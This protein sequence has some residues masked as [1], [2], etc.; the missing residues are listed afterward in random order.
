MSLPA[1]DNHD[2]RIR[3]Y[4][5][6]L[7]RDLVGIEELPLPPGYRYAFY[8]DGDRDDWIEI[9]RSAKEFA[10]YGQG[11][12][13][14]G[15]Y[16][17]DHTNELPERM[18]FVL[19]A[20]DDLVGFGVSAPSIADALKRSRGRL[21]PLGWIRMLRALKTN[22]TLDLFLIALKREYQDK[23]VNA[24]IMNHIL[25]G[26]HKMGIRKAE[27]G[28]QLETNHRVQSQWNFFKTEQHK[29]RRCFIKAL[30]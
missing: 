6:L 9:E 7:E 2:S 4:E 10:D 16:Y 21:L 1:F 25:K 8:R 22:D 19:D 27:T 28:P 29:R 18:C 3:Y 20:Q 26:C 12:D 15:R 14:W 17:A 13:A 11:L 30:E 5:L 23:A 24:I